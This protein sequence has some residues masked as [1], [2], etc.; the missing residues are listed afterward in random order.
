MAN[1]DENVRLVIGR[2]RELWKKVYGRE[3]PKVEG[4]ARRALADAVARIGVGD[5]V[6]AV[7]VYL[8]D[9]WPTRLA[10][11]PGHLAKH[12]DK[13]VQEAK[14]KAGGGHGAQGEKGIIIEGDEQHEADCERWRANHGGLG[15]A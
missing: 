11:D 10:H 2:W 7:G 6:A 9:E 4:H 15:E 5:V 3:P 14:R 8:A 1:A 12:I 13:Y